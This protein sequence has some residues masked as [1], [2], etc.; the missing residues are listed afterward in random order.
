MDKKQRR[1]KK[2]NDEILPIA[3]VLGIIAAI[4]LGFFMLI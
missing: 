4:L 2:F 1:L 3:I